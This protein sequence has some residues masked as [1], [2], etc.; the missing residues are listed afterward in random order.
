MINGINTFMKHLNS[1]ADKP[2]GLSML[3]TVCL[4]LSLVVIILGSI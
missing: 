2:N 1:L 4:A 3:L